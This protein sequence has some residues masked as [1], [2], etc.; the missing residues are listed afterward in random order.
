MVQSNMSYEK[1]VVALTELVCSSFFMR[2]MPIYNNLNCIQN[3]HRHQNKLLDNDDYFDK[4]YKH[5]IACVPIKSERLDICPQASDTRM[6][7]LDVSDHG[8]SERR[9][10]TNV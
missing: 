3:S 2:E 6:C 7:R 1:G 4:L 10:R 8:W 5:Y 9:R